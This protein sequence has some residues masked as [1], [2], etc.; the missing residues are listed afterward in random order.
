MT[1]LDLDAYTL[2]SFFRHG[3]VY[4]NIHCLTML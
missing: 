4:G 2:V 3:L 1:S